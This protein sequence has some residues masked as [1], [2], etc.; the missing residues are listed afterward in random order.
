MP[1]WQK[2]VNIR[3]FF[4][5]STE[6][7]TKENETMEENVQTEQQVGNENQGESVKENS[8]AE[9]LKEELEKAK[10]KIASLEDSFLRER[11][12]FQNYKRRTA[13]E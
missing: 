3:R 13:A 5:M 8:V 7:A 10:Q 9:L 11:A 12:E 6:E 1:L 4:R 2:L